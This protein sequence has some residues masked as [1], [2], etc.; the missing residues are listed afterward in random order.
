[1]ISKTV[2]FVKHSKEILTSVSDKL[3]RTLHQNADLNAKLD[4][5]LRLSRE[6]LFANYFRDSIQ[7]SEWV[8][9]KSFSAYGGAANYSLLYKLYK[10][11]DIIKPDNVL[12]FGL[13]QS[14]KL[15]LQYLENNKSAKALVVDDSQEWIDIYRKQF[16]LPKSLE[17]TK[18]ELQ[19][20]KYNKKTLQKKNEYAGLSRVIGDEKF[21]LVI[22]DGPIGYD[23]DYSRTNIVSQVNSLADDFIVIFDDAERHGEQRTISLFKDQLAKYQIDY[24]EFDIVAGKTQRY[25]VSPSM[26]TAA[27]HI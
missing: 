7:S 3:D 21:N 15:T 19:D 13:G 24:R 26:Y 5:S 6:I 11:Y 18:L 17:L 20:F 22:V 14:T 9:D 8:T 23:K 10:I 1:M 16:K 25:I 27:F 12:E 4:E 2:R